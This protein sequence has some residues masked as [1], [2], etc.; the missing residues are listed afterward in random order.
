ML[1]T[2]TDPNRDDL[3][4]W[5]RDVPLVYVA[6]VGQLPIALDTELLDNPLGGFIPRVYKVYADCTVH[7]DRDGYLAIEFYEGSTSGNPED[8][9]RVTVYYKQCA[10]VGDARVEARN[11]L[12][13][14]DGILTADYFL[15]L[16]YTQ[17]VL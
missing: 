11:A 9:E 5:G 16:G 6:H 1:L 14:A 8:G 12:E 13:D 4:N 7:I 2:F 10:S 3:F 17:E 15:G